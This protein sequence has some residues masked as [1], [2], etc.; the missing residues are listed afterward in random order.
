MVIGET[1][2]PAKQTRVKKK[3]QIYRTLNSNQTASSS[4]WAPKEQV[5]LRD[6]IAATRHNRLWP[7]RLISVWEK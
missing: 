6:L 5:D 3:R 4:M 2:Y 1:V 7:R